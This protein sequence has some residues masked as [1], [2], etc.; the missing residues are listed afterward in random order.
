VE[1][2]KAAIEEVNA[3][4][5]LEKPYSQVRQ[6]PILEKKIEESIREALSAQKKE[7][8]ESLDT[9]TKELEKDLSYEM[10]SD[11]FRET[12]LGLFN[13]IERIIE[14]AEDCALVQS[15]LPIIN[16]LRVEAYGQIDRERQIIRE[17]PQEIH[18]GNDSADPEKPEV[19]QEEETVSPSVPQRNTKVINEISFFQSGKMLEN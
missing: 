17:R 13:V 18:Y 4:L 3:I 8:R 19:E 16:S 6:L 2:T 1:E 9:V 7:I 10:Y 12:V 11:D 5:S 14:E 15:Q